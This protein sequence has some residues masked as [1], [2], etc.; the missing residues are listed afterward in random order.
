M[1]I[2]FRRDNFEAAYPPTH[3]RAWSDHTPILWHSRINQIP[4]E[5]N[6]F[7]SGRNLILKLGLVMV[8]ARMM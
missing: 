1:D 2:I 3:A 4:R 8:I 7:R 5:I 6:F